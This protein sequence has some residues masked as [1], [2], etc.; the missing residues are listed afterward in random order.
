[1]PSRTSTLLPVS[2]RALTSRKKIV[3]VCKPT[4]FL[5]DA[6]PALYVGL[7]GSFNNWTPVSMQ[8]ESLRRRGRS[9]YGLSVELPPGEYQ[10]KFVVN[11]EWVTDPDCDEAVPNEFGSLNSVVRVD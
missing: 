10:Y 4:L 7:A 2:S 3:Q 6:S 8:P 9:R 1:M 5:Y 11:G